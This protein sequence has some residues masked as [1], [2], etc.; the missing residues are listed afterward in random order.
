VRP[1]DII[2]PRRAHASAEKMKLF[3]AILRDPNPIH[4][5]RDE[6]ESRGMGKRL[7]NQGPINVGY[8]ANMLAAASGGP[9]KIRRLTVRLSE[10]VR[11]DDEVVARGVVTSV[12]GDLATLDVWLELPDGSRA[13]EGT[14]VIEIPRS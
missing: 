5:D 7:I 3:A 10:N 8:I 2:D 6:L 1:G 9:E 14:A 4:W 11:E 12:A 13:V